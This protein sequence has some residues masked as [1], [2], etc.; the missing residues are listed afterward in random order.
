MKDLTRGNIYKTFF[1]FALPLVFS[2]VLTQMYAVVDTIIAGQY[3][4]EAGLA[5]TGATSCYITFISSLIWGYGS[6]VGVYIGRLFGAK[7]YGRIK[8]NFWTQILLITAVSFAIGWLSVL[9]HKP[10]FQ[11]LRVDEAIWEEA[12]RYFAVYMGG[13][14]LV[15][16]NSC[17]MHAAT[18]MG[19]ST[20]PFVL[21]VVSGVLNVVGNIFSVVVL[22]MGIFGIGLATVFAS[23]VTYFCYIFYFIRAFRK[24]PVKEKTVLSLAEGKVILGFSLPT[25]FQQG[26]MYLANLLL[27][28]MV[29]GIGPA[30]TAS[31]NVTHRIFEF[32]SAMFYNSSRAVGSYSAQ[33]VGAKKYGSIKKGV[34]AG[35]LQSEL[36]LLPILAVCLIFPQQIVGLFSKEVGESLAYSLFFVQLCLPFTV[37]HCVDNL[38]HHLYRGCKRMGLLLLSTGFASATRLLLGLVLTAT[39]GMNGFY[40]SW[41]ASWALEAVLNAVIYLFGVWIPEEA[42]GIIEPPLRPKR[43]RA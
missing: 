31:Y 22:H 24:M 8:N 32:N 15:V 1:F 39:M 7:E 21:S 17:F 34:G 5:A 18:A 40:I 33:C 20:V 2:G 29:N 43:K 42:K 36:F 4:G 38:F 23:G 28:P 30:A 10:I 25:S 16:L 11:L 35:L 12:F 41:A 37:F 3:L 9:F 26:V 14:C 13:F 6:G 19:A 27:S